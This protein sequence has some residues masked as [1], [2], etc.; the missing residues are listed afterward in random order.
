MRSK[1][2]L[3]KFQKLYCFILTSSKPKDFRDI[4]HSMLSTS[5]FRSPSV[6]SRPFCNKAHFRHPR[7]LRSNYSYPGFFSYKELVL[8][9]LTLIWWGWFLSNGYW[10]PHSDRRDNSSPYSISRTRNRSFR[11][12]ECCRRNDESSC[13]ITNIGS[14]PLESSC[15]LSW[16]MVWS[17]VCYTLDRT[18]FFHGISCSCYRGDCPLGKD[19][20]RTFY[21]KN[22]KLN[23]FVM[24]V[25][26]K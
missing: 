10:W 20:S 22:H 25:L 5:S 14:N 24:L 26:R 7:A 11:F 1:S 9:K 4:F 19:L 16:Q 12:A 18:L 6:H 8:K 2:F 21:H 13:C 15:F 17:R 23:I 3:L